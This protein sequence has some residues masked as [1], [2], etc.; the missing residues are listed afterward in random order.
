VKRVLALSLVMIMLVMFGAAGCANMT[1][2]QQ[3]AVSG[4][5]IGTATGAAIGALAG[6]AA[7]GAAIGGATGLA[8]GALWQDIQSAI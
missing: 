4:G 3:R 6:S 5:V 7:V 8:A 2:E 1:P